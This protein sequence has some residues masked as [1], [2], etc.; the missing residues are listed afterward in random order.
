MSTSADVPP[1]LEAQ[2]FE[3]LCPWEKQFLMSTSADVPP[4]SMTE[5]KKMPADFATEI[6]RHL[7]LLTLY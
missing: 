6:C 2:Y 1:R 5:N 7:L 4:R 3:D